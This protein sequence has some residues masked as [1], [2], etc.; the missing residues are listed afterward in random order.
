VV[1][2]AVLGGGRG[3]YMV[4]AGDFQVS[5]QE[6]KGSFGD[7]SIASCGVCGSQSSLRKDAVSGVLFDAPPYVWGGWTA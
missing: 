3:R 5:R 7:S 6:W 1:R 4:K 2:L